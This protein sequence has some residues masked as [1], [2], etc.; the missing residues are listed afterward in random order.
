MSIS[1]R[2]KA[3]AA[4]FFSFAAGARADAVRDVTPDPAAVFS[5][6][7][8]SFAFLGENRLAVFTGRAGFRTSD[9]RG[10]RWQRAM[11]GFVDA[12][13][14]QPF[15]N[16]FCQSP[17]TPA[18]LYA[19][20][21]QVAATGDISL[22]PVFRSDDFGATWR[23]QGS[24]PSPLLVPLD[25]AVDPASPDVVYLLMFDPFTGAG[26][27]FRSTDA[28]VTW[29]PTGAGLPTFFES[30][31]RT[32]PTQSG[33]VYVSAATGDADDGIYR[34]SDGGDTFTRLPASPFLPLRMALDPGGRGLFVITADGTLYRSTDQGESFSALA[35]LGATIASLGA[36][37][38]VPA[39]PAALYVASPD[40]ALLRSTDFGDT[41]AAVAGT[42]TLPKDTNVRNVGVSS[43]RNGRSHVFIGTNRGPFRSDDDGKSFVSITDGYQGATV[44]DLALDAGGRLV[45]A[46]F[47]TLGIFRAQKA[48]HPRV[49]D[50]FGEKVPTINPTQG[51]EGDVSAVA[52][53][54]TDPQLAIAVTVLNGVYATADGGATWT[55]STLVPDVTL[56]G[57]NVRVAF[58]P[59]SA[60]RAY[61]VRG[62]ALYRSDNAGVSFTRVQ[63]RSFGSM[64]IDP[65]NP[66]VI[67]LGSFF[68]GGL[69]KSTDG[70]VTLTRLIVSGAFR[71]IAIDPR[72]PQVV[73]AASA[74]G[75]VLRS[76]DAGANWT[77]V[78]T[79]LPA[80]E[81]LDVA[82]D[83]L[84]AGRVYAWIKAAGLFVSANDGANWTAADT[85]EAKLRSAIQVGRASM[86]VDRVVPGRVYLG[87][88]G[89]VQ[90]DTR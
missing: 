8:E 1:F 70:G 84:T 82:V 17:S 19:P 73:Y 51:G 54:S 85:G 38:F 2:T 16:G 64:A 40:G 53:A 90:V 22:L 47:H 20:A 37:S 86:V 71:S 62:G 48:G 24:P 68:G 41:F 46:T 81:T 50:A 32:S 72:N 83:P 39:D 21:G 28:G 10:N 58:A 13:G 30:F 59:G 80:G 3:L 5:N 6:F 29:T 25:C 60:T 57:S 76:A 88:N 78:S 31:V 49:Y 74:L 89:V 61:L 11:D 77:S 52:P 4:L 36:I 63:T 9:N 18:I 33:V 79:D 44:N 26:F 66:D 15:G 56:F 67:Y 12:T 45:V 23:T 43:A 55:R 7:S 14:V 42:A 27:L 69:F 65:T 75:G 34:S 87:N 35:A